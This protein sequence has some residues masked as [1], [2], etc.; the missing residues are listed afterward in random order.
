VT[1]RPK[2]GPLLSPGRQGSAGTTDRG[3]GEAQEAYWV[4]GEHPA[5]SRIRR[6]LY[7]SDRVA[8]VPLQAGLPERRRRKRL[9]RRRGPW[10]EPQAIFGRPHGKVFDNIRCL[11]ES[12]YL[13][14]LLPD[15]KFHPSPLRKQGSRKN[16]TEDWVPA[17]AGTT[18]WIS[19]AG[20]TTRP[21]VTGLSFRGW[22]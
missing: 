15:Q 18:A 7:I 10:V 16:Q 13:M 5:P 6:A 3:A 22:A 19:R 17:C 20:K 4:K 8:P 12:R 2:T 9:T 21:H 11:S 1:R 14:R